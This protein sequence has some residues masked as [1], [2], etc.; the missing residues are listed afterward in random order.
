MVD[1]PKGDHLSTKQGLHMAHHS[2]KKKEE[3]GFPWVGILLW[4][5]VIWGFFAGGTASTIICIIII[6][7]K[8]LTPL[9]IKAI[10]DLTRFMI[11]LAEKSA[12]KKSVEIHRPTDHHN[13]H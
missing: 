13:H 11:A 10:I 2:P 6:L 8:N 12:L 5:F 1:I 9:L 7:A 4:C 3:V